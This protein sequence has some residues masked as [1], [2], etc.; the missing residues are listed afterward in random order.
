MT[1]G[2]GSQTPARLFLGLWADA[3][4]WS[5]PERAGARAVAPAFLAQAREAL[6]MDD[7]VAA[8]GRL[9]ELLG[10]NVAD[11]AGFRGQSIAIMR[12]IDEAFYRI[13]PRAVHAAPSSGLRRTAP[14]WLRTARDTRLLTGAYGEDRGAR[15]LPR[16]PLL[17]G[18]RHPTQ[19]SA[20]SLADRFAALGVAAADLR[21]AGRPIQVGLRVVSASASRGVAPGAGSG[22]EVVGFVPIAEQAAD[23]VMAE[24]STGDQA[25]V[26]F[27]PCPGLDPTQRLIDVLA[28]EPVDV[29]LAPE[30]MVSEDE[31]D[32]LATA[33]LAHPLAPRLLVAGSGATRARDGDQPWNEARAVNANGAEIWRQRKLWPAGLDGPRAARLGLTPPA[34]G[35]LVFEDTAAGDRLEVVDA[36]GLGRCVILI[37]QDLEAADLTLQLM[38]DYQP[39]WVF[40]PILDTGVGVDR[41]MHRR[42]VELSGVS[43]ARF[44]VVSSTSLA[45]KA[46]YGDCACAL[47]V[48]PRA[49]GVG[50]PVEDVPRAVQFAQAGAETPGLA[51]IRWRNGRWL[52]TKLSVVP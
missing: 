34:D 42:A 36:E 43:Q 4:T 37:C 19:T 12:A 49:P 16:G 25:W 21:H 17:R 33:L 1:S 5:G 22:A 39:D 26:D 30:F 14:G 23:V 10:T 46:G 2:A 7:G 11:G 31:A 24:R 28:A 13:H 44:L 45:A 52:Q 8:Y 48:G 15:L 51:I 3:V 29:A 41:W 40:V 35:K 20:D 27:R 50:D 6:E 9:L 32:R 38:A 47:A 18:Q